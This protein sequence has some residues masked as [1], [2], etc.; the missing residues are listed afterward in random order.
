MKQHDS[1]GQVRLING[2]LYD[3][4]TL[5]TEEHEISE[6]ERALFVYFETYDKTPVT[7]SGA[8]RVKVNT[9]LGDEVIGNYVRADQV[10]EEEEDPELIPC[11]NCGMP[12]T[13]F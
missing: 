12:T 3:V 7:V 6:T 5:I 10:Q 9:D 13:P 1:I 11:E 8:T 4:I 2:Q